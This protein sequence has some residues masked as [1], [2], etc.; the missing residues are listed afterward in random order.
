MDD[1]SEHTALISDAVVISD[2]PRKTRAEIL[3]ERVQIR[4]ALDEAG[5]LIAE[6]LK[7][8]G[9]EIP[10]ADWNRVF[11][12]WLI[13]CDG[14]Q[15]IGCVQVMPAKPIGYCEFLFA[16]PSVSFKLRAIAIRKLILQGIATVHLG[17]ASYCAC[18][19]DTKNQ[20]F[21]GV[22]ERMNCSKVH[23][24]MVMVKRLT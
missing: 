5:P 21:L 22:L 17:G 14:D 20:K 16:K 3:R 13:A 2:R 9:I 15:V 7:E 19:V 1:R 23:D 12:H 24:G 4:L 11:P 8:N 10:G 18:T 6:V